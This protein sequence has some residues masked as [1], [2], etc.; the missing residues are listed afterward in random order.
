MRRQ[1]KIVS[2]LLVA[3]LILSQSVAGFAANFKDVQPNYWAKSYIEDMSNKNVITGYDDGSFKPNETVSKVQAIVMMVR[4]KGVASTQIYNAGLKHN[5]LLKTKNIPAW[6]MNYVAYAYDTGIIA[7]KD[8]DG[9]MTNSTQTKLNREEFCVYIVKA[10]GLESE[11]KQLVAYSLPFTDK[12]SVSI[13]ASPYVYKAYQ[14]GIINGT[15]QNQFLP[16]AYVTRAAAAKMLSVSY[17]LFHGGTGTITPPIA[18]TF[19]VTGTISNVLGSSQGKYLYVK[20]NNG[21]TV[22]YITTPQT[23]IK[24]E[25][26]AGT[27]NDIQIGKSADLLV[28]A[29]KKI[30]SIN[31]KDVAEKFSGEIQ[32]ISSDKTSL[33]IRVAGVDKTYSINAYTKYTVNGKSVYARDLSVGDSGEFEAKNFVITSAK[34]S[35]KSNNVQGKIDDLNKSRDE[36]TLK[37]KSGSKKEYSYDDDDVSIYIDGRSSRESSVDENDHVELVLQNDDDD[38]IYKMY[39]YTKDSYKGEIQ[40]LIPGSNPRITIEDSSTR[41][42]LSFAVYDRAKIV[43]DGKTKSFEDLEKG[44]TVE[45]ELSYGMVDNI[46]AGDSYEYKVYLVD[47]TGTMYLTVKDSRGRSHKYRVDDDVDVE[48]D[49]RRKSFK[50]LKKGYEVTFKLDSSNRIYEI[51]AKSTS[52]DEIEGVVTHVDSSGTWYITIKDEDRD[53][54]RYKVDKDVEV[55]IDGRDKDYDDIKV[56]Y[57]VELTL[58]DDIVVEIDAEKSE[59][60]EVEGVVTEVDSSGTWYITIDE[61]DDDDQRYRV[62]P[63]VEVEIDGDDEDYEDIEEGYEVEL[64]LDENNRVIKIDANSDGANS[65]KEGFITSLDTSGTLHITIEEDDDDEVRYLVDDD[66]SVKIDGRSEDFNDLE[67][68]YKVKLYLTGSDK[69]VKIEA[70]EEDTKVEGT[71]VAT[72]LTGTWHITVDPKSGSE[73]EYTVDD[74]VDV[75][76]DNRNADFE[77]LKAGDIVEMKLR[78]GKVIEIEAD[79]VDLETRTGYIADID[80]SGSWHI[81]IIDD[82][83]DDKDDA[84]K[85]LVNK[86][87]TVTINDDSEEFEDLQIGY[88]VK[89]YYDEDDEEVFKIEAEERG[90]TISGE[91]IQINDDDYEFTIRTSSGKEHH[92]DMPSSQGEDVIVDVNGGHDFDDISKGDDV[93]VYLDEDGEVVA[94]RD[95]D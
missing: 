29:D 34:L 13:L 31:L 2:I 1:K 79:S 51:E 83:D 23:S 56:G 53:T 49:G 33:V 26:Y 75:E 90:S 30:L 4:A 16:K 32:R 87:V 37:P 54:H 17:K 85:Y 91:V 84:D 28:T 50:Y 93:T 92:W 20:L 74:D 18:G 89:I 80:K 81:D 57:E 78:G 47:S 40:E 86:N 73:K 67:E 39:V 64:T 27:L 3:M 69:V 8:L 21:V 63:D 19:N 59:E 10:L 24:R 62:D 15:E 6:A 71:V 41:R 14:K 35:S 82:A 42:D 61:E 22:L 70:E 7:T 65:T 48:I 72:D 77:D 68:G 43:V 76:I 5:A 12:S 95:R 52:S 9:L 44:Q 60:R 88:E 58:D 25:G 38:E 94:I 66:V 11:V 46:E 55:E 45:V 36:L